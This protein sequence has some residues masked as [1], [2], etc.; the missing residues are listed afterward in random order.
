[1]RWPAN[2]TVYEDAKWKTRYISKL[3]EKSTTSDENWY[4]D[5]NQSI[6]K[7]KIRQFKMVDGR[8]T[9]NSFGHISAV[10]RRLFAF[11]VT[12]QRFAWDRRQSENMHF[13]FYHYR[14]I[15]KNLLQNRLNLR[16]RD[17][18]AIAGVLFLFLCRSHYLCMP[19]RLSKNTSLRFPVA[20]W[21]L[22][23]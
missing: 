13:E 18:F 7:R 22:W 16:R 10:S 1:M 19:D 12:E 15:D 11:N 21:L 14:P 20:L 17:A 2:C 4:G 8:H 6:K 5:Y 23:R 9:V 3:T